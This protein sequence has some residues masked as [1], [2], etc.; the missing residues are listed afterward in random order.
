MFIKLSTHEMINSSFIRR[1][2]VGNAREVMPTA[3]TNG[4]KIKRDGFPE[5]G[6]LLLG[7]THVPICL[8]QFADESRALEVFE[9]I[10]CA[11]EEGRATFNLDSL[12]S[13]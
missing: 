13:A 2:V 6:F 5:D 12:S 1:L 10:H 4:I 7:F 8:A 3:H 9:Q 11:L